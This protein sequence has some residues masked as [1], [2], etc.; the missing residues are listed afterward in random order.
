MKKL[1]S[2]IAVALVALA[3]SVEA[4]AIE[5]PDQPGTI[6]G[7][8]YLGVAHRSVGT[9]VTA[10]YVITDIWKG[11]LSGGVFLGF[12]DVIY[13]LDWRD[14]R[15]GLLPKV[16]YGLNITDKTEVHLSEMIGLVLAEDEWKGI[17]E[18]QFTTFPSIGGS[19]KISDNMAVA[20]ELCTSV[21]MPVINV[22]IVMHF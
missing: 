13:G 5:D 10:D 11:H 9:V 1:F 6:K 21:Y 12:N 22:G 3:A 2:I 17:V 4:N 18:R 8:A 20:V 16:T 15:I 7:G 14:Y 19:Y